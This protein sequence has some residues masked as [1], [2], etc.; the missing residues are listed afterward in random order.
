M[1]PTEE[2]LMQ[3]FEI[4]DRFRA[5]ALGTVSLATLVVSIFAVTVTYDFVDYDDQEVVLNNP[6]VT[7]GLTWTGLR[8]AWGLEHRPEVAM[9]FNWPLTWLTH[10]WDC[11]L[12]GLWAGGH[13]MTNVVLHAC[14]TVAFFAVLRTL[15]FS[16]GAGFVLAAIYGIHPAQI[17]SVA[18]ITSRKN[19]LSALFFFGAIAAYLRDKTAAERHGRA[20]ATLVWNVLGMAAMLSKATTVTLPFVML[21]LDWWP[22]RR[23]TSGSTPWRVIREKSAL[24]A[25][26]A[27]TVA[28]GYRAQDTAGAIHGAG[29]LPDRLGHAAQAVVAYLWMFINPAR[30]SPLYLRSGESCDLGFALACGA[31]IGVVTLA[32]AVAAGSRGGIALGW[33]WFLGTLAPV[34][35]LVQFG[36][37]AWACRHLQIPM[38]GLLIAAGTACS[39]VQPRLRQP[40]ARFGWAAALAIIG[41]C[42][43]LTLRQLPYWRNAPALAQAMLEHNPRDASLW[44]NLAIVL[45]RYGAA[46]PAAIDDLFRQAASLPAPLTRQIEIAHDHGLFLLTQRENAEACEAFRRCLRLARSADQPESGVVGNATTNLAIGLT[47]LDDTAEAVSLL[48]SL[49]GRL[50][51]TP[52]SLNALGNAL[53]ADGDHAAALVAFEEAL[54]LKPDDVLLLCNAAKAA[55]RAGKQEAAR[56]HL[57]RARA[58]DPHG[59]AV[60]AAAA[61]LTASE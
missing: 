48:Q 4:P 56:Q 24:W 32:A 7:G 36:G 1:T 26:A 46:P 28:S 6:F 43:V 59:A 39:A 19:V 37:Q 60:A 33:L 57:A 3:P 2:Q 20:S 11:Q 29:S 21:L 40:V 45:D 44:N 47:R 42:A 12:Y 38:A 49:H 31:F 54:A 5:D 61:I 34:V 50:P 17:E 8:W 51:P 41:G 25:F 16:P 22:L 53:V 27:W 23:V 13:H 10:Q 58:S 15:S 9:W 18:W 35:G 55:A 30:L 14:G 52:A